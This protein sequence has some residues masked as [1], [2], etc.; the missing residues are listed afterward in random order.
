ME[1]TKMHLER[2]ALIREKVEQI[3]VFLEQ[4]AKN[5]AIT[6][7]AGRLFI[8]LLLSDPPHKNFYEI[9]EFLGA[10]KSS[11]STALKALEQSGIVEYFTVSGDRKRYFRANTAKWLE[12]EKARIKQATLALEFAKDVLEFRKDSEYHVFNKGL[13]KVIDYHVFMTTG[14]QNLLKTWESQ[15]ENGEM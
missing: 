13:K 1:K 3:G 9:T 10:S 5:S 7:L 14:L 4:Q 6:P 12:L 15:H 11:I 2:E 8:Y